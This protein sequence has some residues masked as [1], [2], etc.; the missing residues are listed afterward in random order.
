VWF[1]ECA[2]PCCRFV[3]S[4]KWLLV[5]VTTIGTCRPMSIIRTSVMILNA[6]GTMISCIHSF[7][8]SYLK[9]R[10]NFN[11]F[12]W[13]KFDSDETFEFV[14]FFPMLL[15]EVDFR[16]NV[17][18]ISFSSVLERVFN[19]LTNLTFNKNMTIWFPE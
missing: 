1:S 2:G 12:Q 16:L 4:W 17:L 13:L 5:W 15:W 3:R 19:N 7:I 10:Q 11:Y 9:A 18:S 8:H 6:H 14:T